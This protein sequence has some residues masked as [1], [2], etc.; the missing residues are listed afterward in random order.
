[1]TYEELRKVATNGDALIVEGNKFFSWLVRVATGETASHVAFLFWEGEGLFVSEMIE[2]KGLVR[3][4]ASQRVA[5]MK[6]TAFYG[7]AAKVVEDNPEKAYRAML[8][9]RARPEDKKKYGYIA[10]LQV[11]WARIRGKNFR[12]PWEVCST[13]GE[14]IW[15][16]CGYQ[17]PYTPAPG[18]YFDHCQY[19]AKLEVA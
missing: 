10:L 18:D 11:W 12:T 1:M 4:P 19:V 6:G 2:G 3:S 13:Y 8:A 5:E 7:K 14:E 9:F 16:E 15:S 17:F